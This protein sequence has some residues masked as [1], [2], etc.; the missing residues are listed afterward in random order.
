MVAIAL[1]WRGRHCRVVVVTAVVAAMRHRG[2]GRSPILGVRRGFVFAP[3]SE[4][5][6]V[7]IVVAPSWLQSSLPRRC[8]R[9]LSTV[10]AG[11]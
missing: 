11:A 7:A 8:R 4:S 2:H 5:V 10:A 6:V 3:S 9:C 1:R